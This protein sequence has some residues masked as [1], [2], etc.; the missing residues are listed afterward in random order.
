VFDGTLDGYVT[1][2]VGGH[3]SVIISSDGSVRVEHE[4]T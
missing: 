4:G 2:N 3:K 1:N